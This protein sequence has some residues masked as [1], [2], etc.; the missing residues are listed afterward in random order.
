[1]PFRGIVSGTFKWGNTFRNEL[2][3]IE[4]DFKFDRVAGIIKGLT[5]EFTAVD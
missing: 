5:F 1:M 2:N 4:M 3:V